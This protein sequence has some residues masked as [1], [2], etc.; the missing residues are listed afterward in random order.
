MK[1]EDE[2]SDSDVV[3]EPVKKELEDE[4]PV[5][6]EPEPEKIADNG[7]GPAAKKTKKGE[8]K[9]ADNIP[10]PISN[11]KRVSVYSLGL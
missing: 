1:F 2:S 4:I 11:P 10:R 8:P 6:M 3:V 9:P 5:K 7:F